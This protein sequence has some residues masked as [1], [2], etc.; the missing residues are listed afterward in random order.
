MAGQTNM[1]GGLG[2][3]DLNAII[4]QGF[5]F[6]TTFLNTKYGK[7]AAKYGAGPFVTQQA[8]PT[9]TQLQQQ[10]LLQQALLQQQAPASQIS[11]GIGAG[12]ANFA[13]QFGV[14]PTTLAIIGIGGLYLLTRQPPK[15]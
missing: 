14:S 6:G 11:G 10:A 13:A 8:Q 4:Q 12:F 5:S 15:R 9:Q 1:L 7:D 2:A 3:I